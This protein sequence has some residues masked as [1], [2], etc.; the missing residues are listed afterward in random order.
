MIDSEQWNTA[1]GALE[2]AG[3]FDR[4]RLLYN[5]GKTLPY[6][7]WYWREVNFNRRLWLGICP[8]VGGERLIGFMPRNKWGYPSF[9]LSPDED[10]QVKEAVADL[11]ADPTQ[12]KINAFCDLLQSFWLAG[13]EGRCLLT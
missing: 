6:I 7:G 1:L 8:I 2:E 9:E 4:P 11:V 10:A 13:R 12:S 3:R 5:A